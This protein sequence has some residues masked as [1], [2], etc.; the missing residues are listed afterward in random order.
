MNENFYYQPPT[1]PKQTPQ[2][3]KFVLGIIIGVL[4]CLVIFL[5]GFIVYDKVLSKS[6]DNNQNNQGETSP[7]SSPSTDTTNNTGT[8]TENINNNNQQTETI[9]TLSNTLVQDLWNLSGSD[10]IL[11][12]GEDDDKITELYSNNITVINNL[13][14]KMKAYFLELNLKEIGAESNSSCY[15]DYGCDFY[16]WSANVVSNTYYKIYGN[17]AIIKNKIIECSHYQSDGSLYISPN[18][19]SSVGLIGTISK[20]VKATQTDG[21]IIL[22]QAVKFTKT[23]YDANEISY[24]TDY[25]KTKPTTESAEIEANYKRVFKKDSNGNYYFYSIEKIN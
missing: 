18:C 4:V 7:T 14:E 5:L 1:P 16:Y 22:Y 10:M 13:S 6:N 11:I 3:N 17:S 12:N 23:D 25:N 20:L 8:T 21:E 15:K 19:G 24:Y 9:L 2:K